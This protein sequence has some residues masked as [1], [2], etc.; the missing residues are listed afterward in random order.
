MDPTGLWNSLFGADSKREKP[1]IKHD[2]SSIK[3]TCQMQLEAQDAA[4]HVNSKTKTNAELNAM[5]SPQL[6]PRL[7]RQ[8]ASVTTSVIPSTAASSLSALQK[9][10]YDSSMLFG[11]N[12]RPSIRTFI[13][14]TRSIAECI[15][16]L[17]SNTPTLRF[18]PGTSVSD[19]IDQ[20]NHVFKRQHTINNMQHALGSRNYLLNLF[21]FA[22]NVQLQSIISK[23]RQEIGVLTQT[24]ADLQLELQSLNLN[25]EQQRQESLSIRRELKRTQIVLGEA[26]TKH[27]YELAQHRTM[28]EAQNKILYNLVRQRA[29]QDILMDGVIA[30]LA[31]VISQTPV[32]R[33]SIRGL[34]HSV[35]QP[36]IRRTRTRQFSQVIIYVV[37]VLQ[38]RSWVSTIGLH[39]STNSLWKS[40]SALMWP[41]CMTPKEMLQMTSL[42]DSAE[43]GSL[44]ASLLLSIPTSPLP[45]SCQ[46]AKSVY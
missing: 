17:N 9:P 25:I 44:D 30:I 4:I 32:I 40:V 8:F 6:S 28:I 36:S 43:M 7:V 12:G 41:E 2:M 18:D 35:M 38:L 34:T 21:N 5:P 29:R 13:R 26:I 11:Q 23:G 16:V 42:M 10:H 3:N 24:I 22:K 20:M 14:E 37:L 39:S 1:H 45:I 15:G 19:L 33:G 27:K 31:L 46:P